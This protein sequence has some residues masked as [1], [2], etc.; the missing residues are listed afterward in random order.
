MYSNDKGAI[1]LAV[2]R[3]VIE[4]IERRDPGFAGDVE[5]RLNS[6]ALEDAVDDAELFV[7]QSAGWF[8]GE[9]T[10]D[11]PSQG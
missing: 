6:K 5:A 9:I 3:A 8:A 2:M 11:P 7:R 10:A 1:A 4:E